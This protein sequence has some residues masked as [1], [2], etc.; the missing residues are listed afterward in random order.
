MI[1]A[2]PCGGWL[3]TALALGALV[4]R[5]RDLALGQKQPRRFRAVRGL[6]LAS[7]LAE[8]EQAE[9]HR[10]TDAKLHLHKLEKEDRLRR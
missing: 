8:R 9:A 3:I 2:A 6:P 4:L 5:L 1:E 10:L 7:E